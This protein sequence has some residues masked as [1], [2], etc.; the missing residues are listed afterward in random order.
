MSPI[1]LPW[2][3]NDPGRQINPEENVTVTGWG[4]DTNL[5]FIAAQNYAEF[6]A[7]TPV[8]IAKSETSLKVR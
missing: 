6:A 5:H 1:C 3:S 2:N 8:C 7:A 4:R